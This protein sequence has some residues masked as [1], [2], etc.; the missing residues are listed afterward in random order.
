MYVFYL[1]NHCI[2][3]IYIRTDNGQPKEVLRLFQIGSVETYQATMSS[4][5]SII[6]ICPGQ[7]I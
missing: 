7:E 3:E 2:C 4:I 6:K 1:R 5:G